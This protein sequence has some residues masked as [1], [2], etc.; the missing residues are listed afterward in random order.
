MTNTTG[1]ANC[2]GK[3]D[4]ALSDIHAFSQPG[5][6]RVFGGNLLDTDEV[7]DVISDCIDLLSLD[8]ELL[9]K[10]TFNGYKFQNFLSLFISNRALSLIP[11]INIINNTF[12]L[13]L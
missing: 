2:G 5:Y 4:Q 12:I 1:L 3:F 10:I 8:S 9:D 6:M 13:Y 11:Y 7:P